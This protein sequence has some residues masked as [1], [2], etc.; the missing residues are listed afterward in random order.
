MSPGAILVTGAA[1]FVGKAVC[2]ELLAGGHQ[3]RA[4]IRRTALAGS[5]SAHPRLTQIACDL[6][7]PAQ[8]REALAGTTAVVHA[9]YGDSATMQAELALLLEL[10]SA[11]GVT[12]L[13]QFSSIA[14][15]GERTGI[16]RENDP[17]LGVLPPYAVAKAGCEDQ[18]RAWAT[19]G[20]SAVILR[21]GIIYGTGSPF[22]TDKLATRIRAGAWGTFGSAGD[23]MAALVHVDDVAAAVA[24]ALNSPSIEPAPALNITGPEEPRWNGYFTAVAQR[25]GVALRP[26]GLSE[27]RLR[28]AGAIGAKIG[29]RLHIPGLHRAALAPL[30]GEMRIFARKATYPSDRAQAVIGWQPA[31]GLAEGL[32]R[33][34]FAD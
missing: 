30:P 12:R 5:L 34:E 16:V 26:V 25:L 1:G 33:T 17:P 20:R 21:P 13:V 18:V 4:G 10:A 23:G 14:V 2:R 6:A 32:A 31:I 27:R 9:A 19:A 7:D 11:A 22:W 3:V 24:H 8:V 28:T 29:Q 15:Y